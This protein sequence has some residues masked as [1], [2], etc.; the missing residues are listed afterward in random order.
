MKSLFDVAFLPDSTYVEYLI[1]CQED[2][3]SVH[4]RLFD[5]LH[6][7]SRI[8]L[9]GVH[10][11]ENVF[12]QLSKLNGPKRYAL[13]NSRFYNPQLLAGSDGIKPIVKALREALER[14]VI[15]G[16]IYCDHYLLECIS[17]QAPDVASALEAV[18]GVNFMLDSFAKIEA[19]LTYI[20]LTRFKRPTKIILDRSLNRDLDRLA[21]VA[22]NVHTQYPGIRIESLANEGCLAHCPYKLAHDSYIALANMNGAKTPL[23]FNERVGCKSLFEREPYRIMLSP[24]IRPEDIELYYYHIDTIKLC[25]RELGVDF[26]KR[27]IQAYRNRQYDGN[28]LDLLDAT[29]WLADKLYLDNSSLSFDFANTMSLCDGRCE[30]C[31]FC[32]DMFELVAHW[33]PLSLPDYRQAVN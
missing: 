28:L 4:F 31:G 27:V 2:L 7:D 32:K 20:S 18:P 13:L 5:G 9:D 1:S 11:N 25:G 16:I 29:N 21:D 26:L 33:L 8:V 22:L 17:S 15:D 19:Q 14:D 23:R 24:F 3:D 6:L 12:S 10:P 30:K